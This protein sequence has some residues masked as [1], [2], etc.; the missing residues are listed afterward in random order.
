MFSGPSCRYRPSEKA[1]TQTSDKVSDNRMASDKVSDKNTKNKLLDYLRGN[2]EVTAADA[3][4]L[5]DR[6]TSTARRLLTELVAE[7]AITTTGANR[8]RKYKAVKM[9]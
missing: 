8:N 6:S 9:I 1:I 2:G 3:A 5:I 7:G 4:I